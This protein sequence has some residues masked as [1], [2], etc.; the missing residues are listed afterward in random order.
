MNLVRCADIWCM[1]L[2][3]GFPPTS[4]IRGINLSQLGEN[5]TWLRLAVGA[6]KQGN[7]DKDKHSRKSKGISLS[8]VRWQ[9]LACKTSVVT[10][11]CQAVN[12]HIALCQMRS[13]AMSRQTRA[14]DM[15]LDPLLHRGLLDALDALSLGPPMHPPFSRC[16]Q[17]PGDNMF[18]SEWSP[19][20]ARVMLE[21]RFC[22][23]LLATGASKRGCTH[24]CA[25][26]SW[27]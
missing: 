19:D 21:R 13:T 5:G 4:R 9:G 20:L 25:D 17:P 8:H 24:S 3:A 18:T 22:F 6:G 27:G 26:D 12:W 23:R 1:A 15:D 10:C 2:F 7:K 14:S 11:L 16:E